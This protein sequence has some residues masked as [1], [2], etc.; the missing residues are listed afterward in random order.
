MSI[1]SMPASAGDCVLCHLMSVSPSVISM[2]Q[3]GCHKKLE[4]AFGN[5]REMLFRKSGKKVTTSQKLLVSDR[6]QSA[7]PTVVNKRAK[8]SSIV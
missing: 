3:P 1:A 2:E 5:F 7:H 8:I 4:A 6:L